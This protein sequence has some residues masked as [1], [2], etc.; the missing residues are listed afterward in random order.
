MGPNPTLMDDVAIVFWLCRWCK[1]IG[2]V[3]YPCHQQ[4]MPVTWLIMNSQNEYLISDFTILFQPYTQHYWPFVSPMVNSE[5]IYKK[6][7]KGQ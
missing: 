3:G 6:R 1:A 4:M 2:D 5:F 7:A